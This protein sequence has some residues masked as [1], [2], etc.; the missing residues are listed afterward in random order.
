[1]IMDVQNDV[2]SV[3]ANSCAT[4]VS[5]AT[6]KHGDSSMKTN[7]QDHLQTD[8]IGRTLMCPMKR[9]TLAK[10]AQEPNQP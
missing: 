5:S 6:M 4:P 3:H 9:L 7:N 1:M 10:V 2:Y 8:L